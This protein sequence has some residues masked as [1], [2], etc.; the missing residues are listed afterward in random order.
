MMTTPYSNN[1]TSSII[2]EIKKNS[3]SNNIPKHNTQ[4]VQQKTSQVNQVVLKPGCK[5]ASLQ[6]LGEKPSEM[7]GGVPLWRGNSVTAASQL[8]CGSVVLS[9]GGLQWPLNSDSD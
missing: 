8:C 4:G 3:S 5:R 9:F 1:K 6:S 2:Y 7:G